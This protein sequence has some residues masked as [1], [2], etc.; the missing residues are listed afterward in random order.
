MA[1]YRIQFK[2]SVAKD[3]RSFPK[4]DVKKILGKINTLAQD[5]RPPGAKKLSGS[6][7]YRV[8]QGVYRIVYEIVDDALIV[9]AVKAAHRSSIYKS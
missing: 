3:L 9:Y 7:Y 5:P 2:N 6:D 8:R 4:S 1:K